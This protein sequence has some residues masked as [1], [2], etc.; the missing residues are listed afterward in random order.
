MTTLAVCRHSQALSEASS[1]GSSK[2]RLLYTEP[3]AWTDPFSQWL[4]SQLVPGVWPEFVLLDPWVVGLPALERILLK[5][6]GCF[7]LRTP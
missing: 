4:G 7:P 1:D 3:A 2:C 5:Q 6:V